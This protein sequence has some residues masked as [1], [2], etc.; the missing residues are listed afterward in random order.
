MQTAK[1]ETTITPSLLPIY[2]SLF[3]PI[4]RARLFRLLKIYL[5]LFTLGTLLLCLSFSVQLQTFG[6]G[7]LLPGAG[8]LVL[9]HH[10]MVWSIAVLVL[11]LFSVLL[12]FATGNV[13]V[14]PSVWFISALLAS[15]NTVSIKPM[16]IYTVYG[17]ILL[18]A[19]LINCYLILRSAVA[20][21][22]RLIDN[23]YLQT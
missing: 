3:A 8:F 15:M 13:L 17:V 12:W 4:T 10:G 7:L 9:A 5:I 1:G 23:N 11:F 19:L 16:V 20:K 22:Q 21:K 2:Q 6:L 14:P 18:L